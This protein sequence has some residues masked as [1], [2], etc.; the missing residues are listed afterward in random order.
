MLRL[1]FSGSAWKGCRSQ[2]K[3][4]AMGFLSRGLRIAGFGPDTPPVDLSHLQAGA[5]FARAGEKHVVETA[6]ILS[7]EDDDSGVPHVRYHCRLMHDNT[8]LD[9]GPKTLAVPTF[10]ERF[11]TA[12]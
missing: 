11:R 5:T 2:R 10:L 6:R 7:I 1:G 9:A 3:A 4:G 12:L 8:V